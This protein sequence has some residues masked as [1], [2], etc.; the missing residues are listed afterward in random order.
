MNEVL[1]IL[2]V[3]VIGAVC[4]A[5]MGDAVP[6]KLLFAALGVIVS[7]FTAAK[8]APLVTQ[9]AF[10]E[11]TAD[12]V[13]PLVRAVGVTWLCAAASSFLTDLD[14]P[15]AARCA[16]VVGSAELAVIAVPLVMKLTDTAL[17]L[18]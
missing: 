1:S 2:G 5:V 15:G 8:V 17:S 12:I 14:A 6:R 7:T 16:R 11:K 4:A 13:A 3:V 10:R 9:I 18:L